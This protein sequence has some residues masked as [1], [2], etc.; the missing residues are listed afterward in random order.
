MRS[1][2]RLHSESFIF[3]PTDGMF[4]TLMT[5]TSL[6]LSMLLSLCAYLL[7]ASTFQQPKYA[8]LSALLLGAVSFFLFWFCG[9]ILS[10]MYAS[11]FAGN[12]LLNYCSG[13]MDCTFAI[14]LIGNKEHQHTEMWLISSVVYCSKNTPH[15]SF[16]FSRHGS[17]PISKSE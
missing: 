11:D 2:L 13:R 10:D 6:S 8:P 14:V 15:F 7:T 16:S 5:L 12:A 4:S 3:L 17:M 9:G 1:L